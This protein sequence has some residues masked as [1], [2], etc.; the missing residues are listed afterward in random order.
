MTFLHPLALVG[1]VAATIPALLHLLERRVPPEAEFPPLKYLSEAKRQSA[2]RLKLRH[3]LLLFLRT[4][5]VALIVL[6]AARPLLPSPAGGAAVHVPTALAVI[7]DNSP[8]AGAVVDGRA[9]FDRLKV[10]ARGSLA[11]AAA[12]DRLW[13]ILA[14]GVPRA[15]TREALVASVDSTT[16]SAR[17]LDLTSAV[18][19]AARLVDGEPFPAREVHVVSDLQQTALGSGRVDVPRGV[20]ILALAPPSQEPLNRGIGA[21]RASDGALVVT[22]VGTPGAGAAPVTV[23]VHGREVARALAAPGSTVSIALP[24][25]APGW[26]VGEVLLDPDELR[27]DDRRVFAWRRAPPARVTAQSGAGPFVAAALAVLEQAQRVGRGSDVSIG[28]R[29]QAG[30]AVSVVVPP[31]D[32]ALVG[33]V[34]RDLAGRGAGWRFGSRGTPGP[35][36]AATAAAAGISGTPVLRRQ[37]LESATGADSTVLATVSGE[38]WLVHDAGILLVGSRLD[39]A[40]TAL[41]GRPGFVPFIDALVNR[42]ARGETPVVEAEGAPHVEF[43]I[44]GADT[45]GATVY[46][47]DPRESDLTPA[48]AELV[49]RVLGADVRDA[50][51]FAAER[52]A[53]TRGADVSGLLLALALLVAAGELGVAT[54]TR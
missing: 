3:L 13:L 6:A 18:R 11:G 48:P 41:P 9:V 16:V 14:D 39:T 28:D 32:P 4:A 30:A 38:P 53:G 15:G 43:H 29:P 2:R 51:A 25:L 35:I 12:S 10:V 5:L 22:V 19:E 23:R 8:S 40:W 36:V 54:L 33:Q 44:R 45:V 27:A 31:A 52:F 42:L 17:R 24:S 49:R 7:L 1:L 20:R 26:W 47:L 34:N 37:R 21:A 46:G 50:A